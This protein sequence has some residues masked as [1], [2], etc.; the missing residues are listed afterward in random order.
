MPRDEISAPNESEQRGIYAC[1]AAAAA[2]PTTHPATAP[3]WLIPAACHLLRC[4]ASLSTSALVGPVPPCCRGLAV[5]ASGLRGLP[6]LG[7][8]SFVL[9]VRFCAAD[10]VHSILFLRVAFGALPFLACAVCGCSFSLFQ[11]V[12]ALVLLLLPP[13]CFPSACVSGSALFPACASRFP[14]F[15]PPPSFASP[16]RVFVTLHLTHWLKLL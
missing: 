10:V 15:C 13:L 9:L 2:A 16:L 6:R 4:P 12:R 8:L 11:V 7:A 1:F 14:A 3:R 5:L